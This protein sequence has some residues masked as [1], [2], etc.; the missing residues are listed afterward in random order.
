MKIAACIMYSILVISYLAFAETTR[1]TGG[2]YLVC[3]FS[4]IAILCSFA[5]SRD[6]NTKI[7]I[8]YLRY[9][10]FTSATLF[11]YTLS[12]IWANNEWVSF[13]TPWI[14]V[15]MTC[16]FAI[17]NIYIYKNRNEYK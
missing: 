8:A 5:I 10:I 14:C 9:S 11:V 16:V 4:Y 3:Q 12:C 1:L 6:R 13:M 2:L 15:F 17:M 7:D